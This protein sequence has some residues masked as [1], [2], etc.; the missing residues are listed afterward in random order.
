MPKNSVYKLEYSNQVNNFLKNIKKDN[1]ASKII[2]K[3]I[4]EVVENPFDSDFMQPPF[5]GARKK[6]KGKYRVIFDIDSEPNPQII[7]LLKID[8]RGKIYK[9]F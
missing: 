6:R 7:R 3:L 2:L 9:Y 4:E 8:K 5:K 1:K